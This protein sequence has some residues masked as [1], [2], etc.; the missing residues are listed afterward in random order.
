MTHAPREPSVRITS[1]TPRSMQLLGLGAADE[2]LGLLVV[3][4]QHLD[5][6]EDVADVL[7]RVQRPD[8]RRADEAL[9]VDEELP[10]VRGERG[11]RVGGKVG[12]RERADVDPDRVAGGSDRLVGRPRIA[13]GVLPHDPPVALVVEAVLGRRRRLVPA[14]PEARRPRAAGTS[15]GAMLGAARRLDVRVGAEARE[16]PGRVED[17]AARSGRALRRRRRV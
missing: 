8:R 12:A 7:V 1:G 17:P 11:E 10:S 16:R 2:R 15:V 3:Q 13:D 6:V 4:L 14:R 5:V 9:E